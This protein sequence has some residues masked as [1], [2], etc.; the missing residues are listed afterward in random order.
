[1]TKQLKIIPRRFMKNLAF[2]IAYNNRGY[3]YNSI[4][5]YDQ[6]IKDFNK[7]IELNPNYA[8]AYANRAHTYRKLGI[9]SLAEADEKKG[10]GARKAIIDCNRNYKIKQMILPLN[11]LLYLL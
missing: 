6:A 7:A 5:N 1:M 8:T 11:K 4:G 9:T 10:C 3:T 2:A